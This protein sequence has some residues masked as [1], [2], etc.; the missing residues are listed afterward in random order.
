MRTVRSIPDQAPQLLTEAQGLKGENFYRGAPGGALQT[1]TAQTV[2][3]SLM[4][5]RAGQVITNIY[6]VN[7][8]ISTITLSK[9][10]IYSTA[11][12]RLAQSASN[13]T[14]LAAGINSLALSAAYTVPTT[15]AYYFALLVDATTPGSFLRGGGVIGQPNAIGS[16]PVL[17]GTQT[18]QADLPASATITASTIIGWFGWD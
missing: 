4:G 11:G 5:L 7:G 16:N 2:Y 14:N 10:G 12:S 15:G 13:T 9:L 6:I 17:G 3:F 1:I 8:A 18:A